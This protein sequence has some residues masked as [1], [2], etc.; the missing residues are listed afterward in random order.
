M[1]SLGSLNRLSGIRATQVGEPLAHRQ[2][3]LIHCASSDAVAGL[4]A[5]SVAVGEG[6]HVAELVLLTAD[7]TEGRVFPAG[8]AE[9]DPGVEDLAVGASSL[10]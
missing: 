6:E 8:L 7:I 3:G 9:S 10:A 2:E 1:V 5:G 4:A